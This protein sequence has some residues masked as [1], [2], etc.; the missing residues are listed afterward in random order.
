MSGISTSL[1]LSVC[2]YLSLSR[3]LS[4]SA[5]AV[6]CSLHLPSVPH[7]HKH[8]FLDKWATALLFFFRYLLYIAVKMC[9]HHLTGR[10]TYRSHRPRILLPDSRP[11]SWM[12]VYNC[13]L[14]KWN[15]LFHQVTRRPLACICCWRR[16][17]KD[18]DKR[19]RAVSSQTGKHR[20]VIVTL[21][22]KKQD[23]FSSSNGAFVNFTFSPFLHTRQ[24]LEWKSSYS[25][26]RNCR[27]SS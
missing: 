9:C 12:Y 25:N 21:G 24:M 23:S 10:R 26:R 13:G 3:S 7:R 5:S 19:R 17:N 2:V 20:G 1:T 8:R 6:V 16:A 18:A 4:H 27:N 14:R 11:Q 22:K 15:E